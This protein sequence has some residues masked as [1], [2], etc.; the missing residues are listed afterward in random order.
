MDVALKSK[1]KKREREK[2]RK[3]AGE[4][5]LSFV[6]RRDKSHPLKLSHF[7]FLLKK[8]YWNKE[9]VVHICNE[10]LFL[11]IKRTKQCHL[12]PHEWTRDHHAK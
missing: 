10:M 3:R 11:A 9:D 1:K 12:Q 5:S 4:S 2:K 7:P 6:S 8:V